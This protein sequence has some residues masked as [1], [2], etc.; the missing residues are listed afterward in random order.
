MRNIQF[1]GKRT[2]TGEWISGYLVPFNQSGYLGND[3]RMCIRTGMLDSFE[4]DPE[5]IGQYWRTV[6]NQDLYDGDIFESRAFPDKPKW[7]VQYR[8]Q[9]GQ[10]C[11]AHPEELNMKFIYPWQSPDRKWWEDLGSHFHIIGN[12][13]DN[14]ELL[15]P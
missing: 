10:F 11:I 4:I 12:I 3:N 8:E 1:R 15:K 13:H 5:T 6:N 7:V 14:P 2:A 9:E